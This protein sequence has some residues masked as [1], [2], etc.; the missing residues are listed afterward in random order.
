[1]CHVSTDLRRRGHRTG[2]LVGPRAGVRAL[3]RFGRTRCSSGAHLGSGR[4]ERPRTPRTRGARTADGSLG[5][6]SPVWGSMCSLRKD[7]DGSFPCLMCFPMTAWFIAASPPMSGSSLPT[8]PVVVR[9]ARTLRAHI[10]RRVRVRQGN[11]QLDSLGMPAQEGRLRLG[12]S[13]G[14]WPTV[15]KPSRRRCLS[16]RAGDRAGHGAGR[17]RRWPGRPTL[18]HV[19]TIDVASTAE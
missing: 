16:R 11:R 8:L 9:P 7:T 18:P 12:R 1:M 17:D 14:W 15:R 19:S 2:E 13:V 3:D 6:R 4:R 10:R 5:V